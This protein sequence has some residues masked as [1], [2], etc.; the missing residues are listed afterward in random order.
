M[1]L[2]YDLNFPELEYTWEALEEWIMDGKASESTLNL[3]RLMAYDR[4]MNGMHSLFSHKVIVSDYRF[5]EQD[6]RTSSQE[7]Q[8]NHKDYLE[9]MEREH[10]CD[11]IEEDK[12]V[13]EHNILSKEF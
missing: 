10:N 3:S 4:Q 9:Q 7:K 11:N 2:P 12:F 6:K 1:Y 5:W 13:T 8:F